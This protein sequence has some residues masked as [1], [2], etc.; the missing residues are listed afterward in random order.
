MNQVQSK[1]NNPGPGLAAFPDLVVRA[2][3]RDYPVTVGQTLTIGRDAVNTVVVDSPA[4]SRQHAKLEH[5]GTAWTYTDLGSKQGS[6]VNGVPVRQQALHADTEV[7]LGQGSDAARIRVVLHGHTATDVPPGGFRPPVPPSQVTGIPQRP[8]GALADAP[9]ARTELG[10]SGGEDTLTVTLGGVSRTINPGQ[11]LRVGRETDNDLV[12][13]GTTVSRHHLRIEHQSGAWQLHDLGSSSGTWLNRSRVSNATLSG[14]ME[15]VLGDVTNGDRMITEPAGNTAM[16]P[17]IPPSGS[18]PADSGHGRKRSV[19][20]AI[21]AAVTVI[22]VVV[23]G[24]LGWRALQDD[25]EPAAKETLSDPTTE[26]SDEPTVDNKQ[27]IDELARATVRLKWEDS[28]YVWR[29]SGTIID[30][31]NG[32]ILTNAH[33]VKPDAVGSNVRDGY[34]LYNPSVKTPE[35]DFVDVYVTEGSGRSAQPKFT[36]EVVAWDGYLDFAIVRIVHLADR[37][38]F[39]EPEDLEALTEVPIGDS[40]TIEETDRLTLIGYPDAAESTVPTILTDKPVTGTVGDQRLEI[41]DAQFNVDA[42]IAHGYSGGLA[43]DENGQLI[44]VPSKLRADNVSGDEFEPDFTTVL[45][46][47]RPINLAKPLIKAAT[48]DPKNP[49]YTSKYA[50]ALP[51]TARVTSYPRTDNPFIEPGVSGTITGESRCDYDT[52][53]YTEWAFPFGYSGFSGGEHTDVLAVF[54]DGKGNIVGTSVTDWSTEMPKS[55]CLTVTSTFTNRDHP[56]HAWVYLYGG[57]DL[58]PID[59]G[60]RKLF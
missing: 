5:D 50:V 41:N 21:L 35:G 27:L 56:D 25:T 13:G 37:E 15:F 51:T 55:G 11:T 43:A 58:R 45:G 2:A 26:V 24:L 57:G 6:F 47:L 22:A 32:L 23:G 48:Q 7:T 60:S 44:G 8:G 49:D 29:G 28:N 4:V 12:A 40:S 10:G 59:G 52:K 39:P 3:G 30:K 38:S 1:R 18:E 19:L 33:V 9:A 36:A 53:K 20:T 17:P 54:T 42:Q 34:Q 31:E 14:R 46:G 16:L